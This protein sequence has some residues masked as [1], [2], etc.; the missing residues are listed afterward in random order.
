MSEDLWPLIYQSLAWDLPKKDKS[1][2]HRLN[3]L[4]REYFPALAT[5]LGPD[6]CDARRETYSFY[7]LR[8][9]AKHHDRA[10]PRPHGGD[11]IVFEYLGKY[12][13]IDGNNRVNFHLSRRGEDGPMEGITI[14]FTNGRT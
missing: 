13:L 2:Q 5:T 11:I 8:D 6:T 14:S 9:L 10:G 4:A 3:R 7:T 12:V 1:P